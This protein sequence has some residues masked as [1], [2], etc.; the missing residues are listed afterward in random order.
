SARL[1]GPI[2]QRN[3]P[4]K[5]HSR[6]QRKLMPWRDVNESDSASL[7]RR[8]FHPFV[9]QS[10]MKNFCADGFK[11]VRRANVTG[12]FHTNAIAGI[13]KKPRNE[14]DGF[15]HAGNDDDLRRLAVHTARR[16]QIFR[17]RLLQRLVARCATTQKMLHRSAAK[18]PRRDLRPK[19]DWKCI[20]ARDI[21]AKGARSAVVVA[22]KESKALA[23]ARKMALRCFFL[24]AF[25]RF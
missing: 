13:H 16:G 15:L 8:Q 24:F 5:T 3:A 4:G 17:D 7:A 19:L 21:G 11:N 18:C 9:I 10:S 2:E 1:R 22:R 25:E 20:E 12:A 23:I 6:A 14:I